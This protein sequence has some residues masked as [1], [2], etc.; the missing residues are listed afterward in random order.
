MNPVGVYTILIC[1]YANLPEKISIGGKGKSSLTLTCVLS[2]PMD[3]ILLFWLVLFPGPPPK[4]KLVPIITGVVPPIIE[5]SLSW[6]NLD[7]PPA[8]GV[9]SI[10]STARV[11][12]IGMVNPAFGGGYLLKTLLE[13]L[14]KDPPRV[15]FG[16][17]PSVLI[18]LKLFKFESFMWYYGMLDTAAL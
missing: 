3:I 10:D 16:P 15:F 2:V 8:A 11:L 17:P 6:V 13:A 18:P 5:S 9:F 1:Y 14:L 12:Y 4:A 7:F